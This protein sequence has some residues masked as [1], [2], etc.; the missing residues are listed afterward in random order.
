MKLLIKA[1]K[2]LIGAAIA[3]GVLL[4]WWGVSRYLGVGDPG[5]LALGIGGAVAATGFAFYFR[6]INRRY[7]NRPRGR[8]SSRPGSVGDE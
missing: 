5:S 1:H 6:T 7:L 4:L 8:E 3:L 2:L